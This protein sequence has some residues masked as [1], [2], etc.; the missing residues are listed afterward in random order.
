MAIPVL[1]ADGHKM[2][3]DGLQSILR[4]EAAFEVVAEAGDGA[5]AV[6]L[7]R[8]W[9]PELSVM[10]VSLPGMNGV[11]STAAILREDGG[12]RIVLLASNEDD[13]RLVEAAQSGA[14]GL[15]L[16]RSSERE[17]I[18]TMH[19]V[20][21]GGWALGPVVARILIHRRRAGKTNGLLLNNLSPRERQ[22]LRLV[23]EGKSSKEIATL[24][25]LE[26]QTIRSYR[27]T[28]MLKLGVGNAADATRIAITTGLMKETGTKAAVSAQPRE[29]MRTAR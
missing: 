2:M 23:A 15:L 16:K 7:W 26:V 8:K 28:M 24:L 25:Q 22:V 11:E 29:S 18:D 5:E 14:R 21:A 1:I 9:K 6:R 17:L 19:R 4:Q 12:A 3:R 13:E 10:S 20:A 27:K